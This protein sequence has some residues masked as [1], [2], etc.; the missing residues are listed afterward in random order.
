VPVTYFYTDNEA[1]RAEEMIPSMSYGMLLE[2]LEKL[3]NLGVISTESTVS[4]LVVARLV[5]RARIRRSGVS[6]DVLRRTLDTY[7]S[8]RAPVHSVVKALER[9]LEI[10]LENKREAAAHGAG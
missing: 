2:N 4:M 9:A 6:P 10:A 1:S 8:G 7:R 5:D 3:T